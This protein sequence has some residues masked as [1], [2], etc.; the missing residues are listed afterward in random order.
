MKTFILASLLALTAVSG[1]V[2]T[3]QS[4]A[5]L[6][7]VYNPNTYNPNAE[8]G[9]RPQRVCSTTYVDRCCGLPPSVVTNCHFVSR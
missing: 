5:A 9:V 1:V 2:V 6:T 7:P 8:P 4:A 3:S